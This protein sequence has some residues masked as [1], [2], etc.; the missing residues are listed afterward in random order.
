MSLVRASLTLL[1][2][3]SCWAVHTNEAFF[4]VRSR[5]SLV[6]SPGASLGN[7]GRG[8]Q[9]R[10]FR[11]KGVVIERFFWVRAWHTLHLMTKDELKVITLER[12]HVFLFI[13]E[14]NNQR[15]VIST[16]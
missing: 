14:R 10:I 13:H 1:N 9:G 8:L 4:F 5:N 16:I 6:R 7:S 12:C 11:Q 2:A 15:Q 3:A